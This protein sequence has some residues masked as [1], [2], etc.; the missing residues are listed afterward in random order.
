MNSVKSILIMKIIASGI[1]MPRKMI[2]KN[3]ILNFSTKMLIKKM[4]KLLSMSLNLQFT[5]KC[6]LSS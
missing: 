3:R 1:T 5:I 2:T 6:S 4:L